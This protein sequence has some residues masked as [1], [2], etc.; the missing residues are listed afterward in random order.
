MTLF[1]YDTPQFRQ[2]GIFIHNT[3]AILVS[4]IEPNKANMLE[5]ILQLLRFIKA[6]FYISASSKDILNF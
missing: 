1:G 3:E 4:P 6:Y 5:E 2:C